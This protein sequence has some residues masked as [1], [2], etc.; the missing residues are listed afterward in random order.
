M[1]NPSIIIYSQYRIM[2]FS[3]TD[4]FGIGSVPVTLHQLY[5]NVH[6]VKRDKK[7]L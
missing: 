3:K 5:S 2:L 4:S 1:I 6:R 7:L